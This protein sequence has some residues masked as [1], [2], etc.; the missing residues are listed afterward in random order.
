MPKSLISII[1]PTYNEQAHIK[2]CLESLLS[3]TYT[4]TEIIVV[5]DGSTDQTRSLIKSF[6]NVKLLTQSHQ[7][8]GKARNLG[9][10]KSRG[11]IL[12]FVDA[13]MAFDPK[14][15]THLTA[16]I[17][18]NQ[19][20][21]TFS[22][23]E[24]VANM[25]NPWARSWSLIRGF[26]DGHMHPPDFPDQQPV[27]RAIKKKV[28]LKSGGF[29]PSRGYDD[30]WSLSQRL[31]LMATNAPGAIFY[32]HNPDSLSEIFTQAKWMSK[33]RYKLGLVGKLINIL[34]VF[35]PLA[36]LRTIRQ[37]LILGLPQLL[38]TKLV[39]DAATIIGIT[40]TIV[41]KTRSK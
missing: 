27:F 10:R 41:S 34:K 38:I 3:Q 32:H 19:S 6:K 20:L 4:P 15:I 31:G 16:P 39:V 26:K 18:K 9:A 17:R 23:Q 28:F 36:A 21:G 37:S 40:Q 1:I 2:A 35:S 30:D 25:D 12:V 33:R 13:D 5:D 7:G 8:P 11:D 24:L 22:K 29:D 14:F